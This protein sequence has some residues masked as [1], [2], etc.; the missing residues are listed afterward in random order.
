MSSVS[1]VR[2]SGQWHAAAAAEQ[3]CQPPAEV[4]VGLRSI[5]TSAVHR[6]SAAADPAIS[7]D[8][9]QRRLELQS[10]RA[11]VRGRP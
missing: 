9:R 6:M 1:S 7:D 4:G 8:W 3:G 2:Q 10:C 11:V 5:F